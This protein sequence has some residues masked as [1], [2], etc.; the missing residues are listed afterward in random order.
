MRAYSPRVL[1][2]RFERLAMGT[3]FTDRRAHPRTPSSN[4]RHILAYP[5]DVTRLAFFWV[6]C[7]VG[8]ALW[9]HAHDESQRRAEISRAT[10]SALSVGV[11]D[12]CRANNDI[13]AQM[14]ELAERLHP[15]TIV[16]IQQ[17]NCRQAVLRVLEDYERSAPNA[18]VVRLLP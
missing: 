8:F 16:T 17:Q 9:L 7:S 1:L 10:T 12:G 2:D 11:R 4:G 14:T 5:G 13:R 6:V 15:H 18:D 3:G